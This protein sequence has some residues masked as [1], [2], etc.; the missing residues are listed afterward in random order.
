MTAPAVFVT[1]DEELDKALRLIGGKIAARVVVKGVR[2]GM[3]EIRKAIRAEIPHASARRAIAHKFKKKKKRNDYWAVVG[4]GVGKRNKGKGGTRGG[5]GISKQ[6]IHW[7][8]MGT[9]GRQSS[10]GY[11]GAMP[12]HPAV[13]RGF[14]KS[15]SVAMAKVQQKVR[16]ELMKEITKLQTRRT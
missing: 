2:A 15:G 12:A 4:G 9:K 6:N 1:G 3:G 14:A 16:T 10:R 8:L 7:Y 5:V 11:R 13:R